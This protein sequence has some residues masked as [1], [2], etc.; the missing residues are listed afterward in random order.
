[1]VAVFRVR[2]WW[3]N[4]RL[5]QIPSDAGYPADLVC[6]SLS[7]LTLKGNQLTSVPK[8]VE[9]MCPNLTYLCFAQ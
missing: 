9:E 4:N 2:F 7:Y 6:R 1:M 8:W 5:S 3:F